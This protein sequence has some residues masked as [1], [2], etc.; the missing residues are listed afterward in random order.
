[1]INGL[2][3]IYEHIYILFYGRCEW[4]DHHGMWHVQKDAHSDDL[5]RETAAQAVTCPK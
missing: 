1:M 4:S 2:A 3:I 5:E